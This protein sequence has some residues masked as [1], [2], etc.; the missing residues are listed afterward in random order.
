MEKLFELLGLGT[1]FLYAG[2]TF[3]LFQWLDANASE[4]A[5]AALSRLLYME[6]YDNNTISAALVELFDCVYTRNLLTW[7]AFIRSAIIT[8]FLSVLYLYEISF[9]YRLENELPQF[10][11][12]SNILYLSG[13]MVWFGPMLLINIASD[14]FSLFIVRRWLVV[15]GHRPIA[16]LVISS[17]IAFFV[18]AFSFV[19]RLAFEFVMLVVIPYFTFE[20]PYRSELT[21]IDMARGLLLSPG[22]LLLPA[23]AVF[24]WLPL[25]G[26]SLAAVRALSALA[27]MVRQTQW[28]LKEGHEHPLSAVG[29]VAAVIVFIGTILWRHLHGDAQVMRL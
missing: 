28:L 23:L 17:L 26:V 3:A 13:I 19:F 27:P 22:S 2:A 10:V 9:Y 8:I 16:A 6:H 21:M 25:F 1:P 24:S 7:R 18:F 29:Y 14:F 4:D 12:E 11:L 20:S 5:K 15:A